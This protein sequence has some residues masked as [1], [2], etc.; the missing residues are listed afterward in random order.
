MQ[1]VNLL[2]NLTNPNI[3]SYEESFFSDNVLQ[4]VMEY[5]AVGDLA[6]YISKKKEAKE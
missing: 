1:E 5:C 4:I 3:V 6:F 2:K